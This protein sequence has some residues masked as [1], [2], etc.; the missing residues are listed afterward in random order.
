MKFYFVVIATL[1]S[2]LLHAQIPFK[3]TPRPAEIKLQQGSLQLN[4]NSYLL[5]DTQQVK[6]YQ[7]L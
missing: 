2:L 5:V 1:G 4:A 6:S 3:L 7:F